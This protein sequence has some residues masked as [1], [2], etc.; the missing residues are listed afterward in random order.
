M[1]YA[2][3]YLKYSLSTH[4]ASTKIRKT[5]PLLKLDDKTITLSGE[6]PFQIVLEYVKKYKLISLLTPLKLGSKLNYHVV[7]RGAPVGH[8]ASI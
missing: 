2:G 1:L 6:S 5:A 3:V 4:G 8:K 7:I